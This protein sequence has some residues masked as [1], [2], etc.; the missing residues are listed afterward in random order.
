[1]SRNT[2]TSRKAATLA[3]VPLLALALSGLTA[4]QAEDDKGTVA[5]SASATAGGDNK[6]GDKPEAK[7]DDKKSA[8]P[9]AKGSGQPTG[10]PGKPS[11][12][13]PTKPSTGKG[14]V[15][16]AALAE[17]LLNAQEAPAGYTAGDATPSEPSEPGT[18][19]DIAC[20]VL[21]SDFLTKDAADVEREFG[22]DDAVGDSVTVALTSN[23]PAV[24]K[25][26]LDA[27]VDAL[28]MCAS[29]SST[30]ANGTYD[31]RI[32][33]V[34]TGVRG[35]DSVTYRLIVMKGT[36]A[37]Y[38][39]VTIVVRNNTAM[40]VGALSLDGKPAEPTQFVAGQLQKMEEIAA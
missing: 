8:D 11:T 5:A 23:D 35:A 16:D 7:A 6:T 34:R 28:G 4:C 36:D 17:A 10:K 20:E 40:M 22:K 24:L 9:S 38:G 25:E 30:D 37:A 13:K 39:H 14:I 2:T 27:Y 32:S 29:F 33:D 12:A 31:Y 3:A 1:M 19:S 15:P 18:V 21:V 26:R